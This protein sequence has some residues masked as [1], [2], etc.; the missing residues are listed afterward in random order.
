MVA[1]K[2]SKFN[3]RFMLKA[4]RNPQI[5]PPASLPARWV[6]AYGSESRFAQIKIGVGVAR[7]LILFQV[8]RAGG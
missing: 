1:E 6:E 3:P 4:Q 2:N 5:S 8:K 7:Y